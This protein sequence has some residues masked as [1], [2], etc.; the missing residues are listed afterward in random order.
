[1]FQRGFTVRHVFMGGTDAVQAFSAG[2]ILITSRERDTKSILN[3]SAP[4]CEG[5]KRESLQNVGEFLNSWPWSRSSSTLLIWPLHM[6]SLVNEPVELNCQGL[7]CSAEKHRI[8]GKV[9]RQISIHAFKFKPEVFINHCC[10]N[11][12]PPKAHQAGTDAWNS[13]GQLKYVSAVRPQQASWK[14]QRFICMVI[15]VKLTALW[16][17][18]CTDCYCSFYLFIVVV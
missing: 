3:V 1:M 13:F 11:L 5:K 6:L 12:L 2:H 9:F 10:I 17:Q 8:A 7:G 4:L 18:R 16:S 15:L 14:A